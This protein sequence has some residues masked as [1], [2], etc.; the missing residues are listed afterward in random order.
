MESFHLSAQSSN[1]HTILHIESTI[2]LT[3]NPQMRLGLIWPQVSNKFWFCLVDLSKISQ[4][5]V[6]S[7]IFV[8]KRLFPFNC[9]FM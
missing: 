4:I 6:K 2:L 1:K 7:N 9:S 8:M 3:L 5:L